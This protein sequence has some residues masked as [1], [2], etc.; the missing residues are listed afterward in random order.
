M[1]KKLLLLLS[2]TFY[3]LLAH[4]QEGRTFLDSRYQPCKKK[5]AVYFYDHETSNDSVVKRIIMLSSNRLIAIYKHHASSP[6]AVYARNYGAGDQ[7]LNEGLFI[8]SKK[9]GEWYY[10]DSQAKI[11]KIIFFKADE[12]LREK[13]F[14]HGLLSTEVN[15]KNLRYHGECKVYSTKGILC[16]KTQ[17]VEGIFTSEETLVHTDSSNRDSIGDILSLVMPGYVGGEEKMFRFI[18]EN[19]MYPKKAIQNGAE[20]MLKVKFTITPKGEVTKAQVI[21][22][23]TLGYG[24]EEEAIRVTESMPRWNPGLQNGVPVSVYMNLPIRFR[25]I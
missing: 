7:L 20:G 9:E 8:R 3:H 5:E 17:F 4:A 2:F 24:C 10:Y 15:Y 23:D 6:E 16:K 22:K 12:M 11:D 1:L 21:S 18:A 13:Y 19:M 25:L 14:N